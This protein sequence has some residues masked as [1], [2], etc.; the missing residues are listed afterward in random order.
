[1][2]ILTKKRSFLCIGCSLSLH[3]VIGEKDELVEVKTR[4][5]LDALIVVANGTIEPGHDLQSHDS[6]LDFF[7]RHHY[8]LKRFCSLSSAPKH[9]S[10]LASTRENVIKEQD[11]RSFVL[12]QTVECLACNEGAEDLCAQD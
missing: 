8:H 11:K 7:I 5:S 9:D 10:G 3:K 6:D 4:W 1:M 2:H 12:G